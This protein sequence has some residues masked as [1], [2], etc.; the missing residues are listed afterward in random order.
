ME[1]TMNHR[2]A[3]FTDTQLNQTLVTQHPTEFYTVANARSRRQ[4]EARHSFIK[5]THPTAP[6]PLL[7]TLN[8]MLTNLVAERATATDSTALQSIDRAAATIES[9][10]AQGLY[11]ESSVET[12][13]YRQQWYARAAEFTWPTA[14]ELATRAEEEQILLNL[15]S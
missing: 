3:I 14:E 8:T 4:A 9:Q 7:T 12:Q 10:I 2:L 11:A 5:A 6:L 15:L 13:A 1:L